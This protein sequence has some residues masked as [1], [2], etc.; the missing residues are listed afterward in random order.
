MKFTMDPLRHL[1]TPNVAIKENV[2]NKE[3]KQDER[4][5]K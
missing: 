4:I 5:Q 1:K 2:E 3:Q